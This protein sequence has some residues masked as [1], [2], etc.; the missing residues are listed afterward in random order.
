MPEHNVQVLVM[1]HHHVTPWRMS[2]GQ[3]LETV[4]LAVFGTYL[5]HLSTSTVDS[6]SV[7]GALS[8]RDLLSGL[9]YRSNFNILSSTVQCHSFTL[10][11]GSD[12]ISLGLVQEGT[13]CGNESV[14]I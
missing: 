5:V 8:N 6:C 2:W 13:K 4:D 3:T 9:N 7:N 11:P 14:S 1:H 12:T 10:L